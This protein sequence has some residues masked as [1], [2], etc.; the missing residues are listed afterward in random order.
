MRKWIVVILGIL[1]AVGAVVSTEFGLT[2]K[3]GSLAA[4]L[5]AALVYVFGE[6][7]N[8]LARL[9][10]QKAKWADPKFWIAVAAAVIGALGE[11]GV[12]LPVAPELI[13]TVL[14]VLLGV[15][16]K[17]KVADTPV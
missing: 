13:I 5:T 15:L 14:T 9:A 2:V 8:D 3:V 7:K 1:G 4:M 10:A 16:F 11:A 6:A 12:K 17:T